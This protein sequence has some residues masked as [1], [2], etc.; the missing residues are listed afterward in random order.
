[1]AQDNERAAPALSVVVPRHNG[2][3]EAHV[4][5]IVDS[6]DLV[7]LSK[8]ETGNVFSLVEVRTPSGASIPHDAHHFE[9]KT[10][11]VLDGYYVFRIG[12]E[13]VELGAGDL[14]FVPRGTPHSY[15]NPDPVRARMLVLS[16]PGGIHQRLLEAIGE[17][18]DQTPL[19]RVAA[20]QNA[21]ADNISHLPVDLFRERANWKD[22]DWE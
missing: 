17:A 22:E 11:Y 16:T 14:A 15:R 8:T 2:A 12:D 9:D 3:S 20:I 1:M 6:N 21:P 19:Q 13:S 4:V 5:R 10:F 7:K 18:E